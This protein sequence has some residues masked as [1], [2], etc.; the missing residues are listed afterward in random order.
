MKMNASN[1][2]DNQLYIQ[3]LDMLCDFFNGG[4]IP[5]NTSSTIHTAASVFADWAKD[6]RD[7]SKLLER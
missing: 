6:I 4:R 7:N 3:A 1:L 2:T 5:D